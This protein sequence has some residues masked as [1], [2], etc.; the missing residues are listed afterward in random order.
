M[1][2]EPD[3]RLVGFVG[4]LREH[5]ITAGPSETVDAGR[6]LE[7]LGLGQRE[8]MRAGL[9]SALLRRGGQRAVFDQVFDLYF[10]L[11]VGAPAT[12]AESLEDYRERLA[13]AL[14]AGDAAALR[15]LARIG[16]GRFGA[17]EG[18]GGEQGGGQVG[19]GDS[20]GRGDSGSG[21]GGAGGWSAH[22]ALE[23]IQPQ[24]LIAGAEAAIKQGGFVDR[25]ARDTARARVQAFRELVRG[26]ARRRSAEVRGRE[27]IH[28]HAVSPAAESTELLTLGTQQL[29]ELRRAVAPL[30]RKLATRLAVRRAKSRR[31]QLDLRRTLRRS[32]STGGV[33]MRPVYRKPRPGRPELVLLCDLSGSVANFA[34]FTLMLVQALRDQFTR[35][36]VFAFVE[37][38][39]EVT[40]L[41]SASNADPAAIGQRLREGTA[42][43]LWLANTDYGR[44]FGSFLSR[45][46]DA[47]TPGTSVLVL[48]DA[49]TNYGSPNLPAFAELVG[50]A[51]AVH[52]L[53][54]EPK[55]RWDTGD[56]VAAQYR[57]LAGMHECRTLAQL[58]NLVGSLLPV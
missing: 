19:Q 38:T 27:R 46:A 1:S 42:R 4:A 15:E 2:V 3:T 45:Y 52:W 20:Q 9:A 12:E 44:A 35:V 43:S 7:V 58:T 6:V 30:A 56:S 14:G 47:L 11:G 39:R 5:G 51:R 57:Q 33:P 24:V 25:L 13:A 18:G 49:R 48:G 10:P 36:R 29:A 40:D 50:S 21:G 26:D 8:R 41:F 53:N 34:A 31:G 23:A 55:Q 54:P 37:Q 32:M 17:L 28:R 22:Q 16:V